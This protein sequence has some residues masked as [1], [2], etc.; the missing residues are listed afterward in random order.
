MN[1]ILGLEK[2]NNK[3]YRKDKLIKMKKA[4]N[5]SGKLVDIIESNRHDTY[6]CPVCKEILTRKFGAKKQYFAHPEGKGDS[7]ELKFKLIEKEVEQVYTEESNDILLKQYYNKKFDNVHIDLS[8]IHIS[9][10]TRPY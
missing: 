1:L 5:K 2:G 7:C 8:L 6:N 4:Y 10:P 9:E 3:I